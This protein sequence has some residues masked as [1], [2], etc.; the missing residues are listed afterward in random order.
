MLLVYKYEDAIRETGPG[1]IPKLKLKDTLPP[2]KPADVNV[3][4]YIVKVSRFSKSSN[5]RTNKK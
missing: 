1:M 2:T 3:R 4:V 5:N